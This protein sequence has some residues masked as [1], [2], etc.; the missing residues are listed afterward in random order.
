MFHSL[1][2]PGERARSCFC[3]EDGRRDAIVPERETGFFMQKTSLKLSIKVKNPVSLVQ[4]L[5]PVFLLQ[6]MVEET[7]S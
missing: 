3:C 6:G 4:C 1:L 7:R 2:S 5:S